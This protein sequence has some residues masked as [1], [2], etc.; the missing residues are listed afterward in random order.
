ML[1]R[2]ISDNVC[3]VQIEGQQVPVFLPTKVEES[4]VGL[5]RDAFVVDAMAIEASL[6]DQSFRAFREILVDFEFHAANVGSFA[7]SAE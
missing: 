6:K 7:R 5:A 1:F 2:R 3:K 4:G